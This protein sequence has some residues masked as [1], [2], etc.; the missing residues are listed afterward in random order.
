M[1]NV[2]RE[3]YQRPME[4]RLDCER[5]LQPP[6]TQQEGLISHLIITLKN[7]VRLLESVRVYVP[8]PIEWDNMLDGLWREIEVSERMAKNHSSCK[9]IE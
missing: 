3:T 2:P 1:K 4:M 9:P 8:N 5:H 7:T 6:M